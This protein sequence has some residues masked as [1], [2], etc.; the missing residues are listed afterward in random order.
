[1]AESV[2]EFVR[3]VE[4]RLTM[5]SMVFVLSVE[6]FWEDGLSGLFR[7]CDYSS[8]ARLELA[9]LVVDQDV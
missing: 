8:L 7:R 2:R 4:R 3:G 6:E 1:M 5:R 9:D